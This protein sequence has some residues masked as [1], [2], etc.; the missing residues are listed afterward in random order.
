MSFTR[1]VIIT[2][3]SGFVG[4]NLVAH[5]LSRGWQVLNLDINPPRNR[6][7]AAYWEQADVRNTAQLRRA[8]D[9]FSPTHIFHMAARTDL[10]G[11]SLSEY[12]ANTDGV[13]SLIDSAAGVPGL[14]RVVFASSMLVC[15]LGYLPQ[16]EFDFAPNTVYGESKVLGEQQVRELATGRFPWTIVRPTSLWGPWFDIPYKDFFDAVSRRRYVHPRGRRI[17]RSYGFV[18]NAVHQIEKIVECQDNSLVDRQVFYLADYE[19]IELLA[20]SGVISRHFGVAPPNE[21]PLS[22]LKALAFGGD[23]LKRAG[24]NRVPISTGRLNNLLTEAVYDLRPL[25]KVAGATPYPLEAAVGMT[26]E[27]M[28][29][30]LSEQ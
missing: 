21:V 6:A 15:R 4:T 18:L 22:L 24:F 10:D 1:R 30:E 28:N 27:W 14:Q 16:D 7:Q 25:Q 2:G 20:W 9:E 23:L 17:R 29:R 12:S 8:F 19:P 13:A 11:R 3:G 26:V 5:G